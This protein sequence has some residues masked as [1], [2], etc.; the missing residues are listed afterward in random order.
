MMPTGAGFLN[1]LIQLPGIDFYL[2]DNSFI[3]LQ[4]HHQHLHVLAQILGINIRALAGAA[5]PA[6]YQGLPAGIHCRTDDLIEPRI[7][8]GVC[9]PPASEDCALQP[10]Y[11]PNAPQPDGES[12]PT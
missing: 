2:K 8:S 3:R 1:E 5:V 4:S 11:A 10:L 6:L 7:R 12:S 9:E